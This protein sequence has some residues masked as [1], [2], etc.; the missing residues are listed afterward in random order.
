M[1]WDRFHSYVLHSYRWCRHRLDRE[2]R[3]IPP[4][5]GRI[6]QVQCEAGGSD[7]HC[8]ECRHRLLYPCPATTLRNE[9]EAQSQAQNWRADCLW[10]RYCVSLASGTWA[11]YTSSNNQKRTCA[12]SLTRMI[13]FCVRYADPDVL[14]RQ[15]QDAQCMYVYSACCILLGKI[16]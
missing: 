16:A 15:G 6:L 13:V 8:H 2:M 12:A 5:L 14:W 3:A 10:L 7:E 11:N 1:F 4:E 9:V